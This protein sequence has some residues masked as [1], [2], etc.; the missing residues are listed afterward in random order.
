MYSN[1][2]ITKCNV[3]L[4]RV[5]ISYIMTCGSEKVYIIVAEI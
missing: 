5:N 1:N 3:P 2:V 4:N